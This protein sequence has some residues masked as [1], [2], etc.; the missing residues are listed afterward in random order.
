M[1]AL[2]QQKE[3]QRVYLEEHFYSKNKDTSPHRASYISGGQSKSKK[4][5]LKELLYL[6]KNM[7]ALEI[8]QQVGLKW[9]KR[10][11]STIVEES[12]FA[13][14]QLNQSEILSRQQTSNLSP[15]DNMR[16]TMPIIFDSNVDVKRAKAREREKVRSV[17]SDVRE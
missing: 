14:Q 2:R 4:R 16:Q 5:E 7:V 9:N 17:E 15:I 3:K 12:S 8:P 6:N 11:S 1:Q 10:L 13:S